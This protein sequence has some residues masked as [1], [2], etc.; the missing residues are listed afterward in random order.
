LF[1]KHIEIHFKIGTGVVSIESEDKD[2]KM[3]N[4]RNIFLIITTLTLISS[5][6]VYSQTT[7][8]NLRIY[9]DFRKIEIYMIRVWELV[10]RFDDAKAVQ[11]M[12]LAKIEIDKAREFLFADQ[13]R[14]VLARIHMTKAKQW[15]DLAAKLVLSK[16][17]LNLKAQLDDLIIKAE[18]VSAGSNRDEVHYLLN[19][20]K[21][22]RR[23]AYSAFTDKRVGRGTEYFRISFFFAQKCIDYINT[24]STNLTEQFSNLEISVRQL[25]TQAEELL[26]NRDKEY[27]RNLLNEAESHFE[28]AL[29]MSENGNLQMAI[30]RLR[31]IKRLMYRIFDQAER[32]LLSSDNQ[33]EN[34]LYTLR[35][36][37]D[38]LDREVENKSDERMRN[39]LDRAWQLYREA[40]QEYE[41]KNYAK[42]QGKISLCQRFAN[43]IFRMTRNS[44]TLDVNKLEEQLRETQHILSLQESRINESDNAN[45]ALLYQE[46][47]RML[48]R[49][50]TA[51]NSDRHG[52]AFQL[53][54]AATRMSAR[55]QRELRSTSATKDRASL[56][57]KYQRVMNSITNLESNEE[58]QNQYMAI[59]NQIR[60]F[61]ELGKQYLDEGNYLLADE[62]FST[63]WEQINSYTDKWRR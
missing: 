6:G 56:E 63:A 45:I 61:A 51:L 14:Y 48:E 16:P 8:N 53:I 41:N 39:L 47:N 24:S 40:E 32:G 30:S 58:I 55:I 46:A 17:I 31:L 4:K 11:Y 3:K 37:L 7:D 26:A 60:R 19:Q 5:G 50:Q 29:V 54:Q 57:N 10:Q 20:A 22:Y 35:G 36:F 33:L 27:L 2:I 12:A 44:E 38:A 28:E 25:L 52:I 21:K 1:I 23:L 43:R 49:A 9:G 42:S 13:P 34:S 59:L 18:N 62:Y 15:A